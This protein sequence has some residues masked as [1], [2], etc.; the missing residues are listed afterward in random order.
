[1]FDWRL[2]KFLRTVARNPNRAASVKRL[3]INTNLLTGISDDEAEAVFHDAAQVRGIDASAFVV[4]RDDEF[5][6]SDLVAQLFRNKETLQTLHLDIS[7]RWQT[8]GANGR[9][10][11]EL[12]ASL[13]S[14][15]VLRSLLLSATLPYHDAGDSAD[16][17]ASILTRLLPQSIVSLQVLVADKVEAQGLLPRLATGFMRLAQA[18]SQ[19]QFRNLQSVSCIGERRLDGCDLDAMFAIAGVDFGY[20][21]WQFNDKT[22]GRRSGSRLGSRARSITSV[23]SDDETDSWFDFPVGNFN[24]S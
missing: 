23:S 21:C 20:D 14:F 17:H 24:S 2:A 9:P 15:P 11:T 18:A 8:R 16:E 4:L 5:L 6:L 7:P 3:H 19:G 12:L 10:P 1:D 22:P 13:S